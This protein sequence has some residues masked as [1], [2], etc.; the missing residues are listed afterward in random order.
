MVCGGGI[1]LDLPRNGIMMEKMEW[2]WICLSFI[3]RDVIVA[4]GSSI[5]VIS[6]ESKTNMM[7]VCLCG[8]S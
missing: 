4:L 5:G 3:F 6:D 8:H 7:R 1:K 2:T